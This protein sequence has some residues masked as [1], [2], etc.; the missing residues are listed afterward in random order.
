LNTATLTPHP[1]NISND[2]A[3][4]LI[5]VRSILLLALLVGLF[6]AYR[7]LEAPLAYDVLVMLLAGYSLVTLISAVRLRWARPVS[8]A[9]Y[10][11]QLFID[12]LLLTLLVYFSGGASNPFISLYIVFLT[13]SAA[14]LPRRTTWLLA[15]VTMLA[16]SYLLVYN[17]P[18]EPAGSEAMAHHHHAEPDDSGLFN[19][20]LLGM[21]L[22]FLVSTVLI[23]FFVTR[24]A[25][26]IRIQDA[27]LAEHR[28]RVLQDEQLLAVATQAAG[29]AHEL[30]TPLSTIAVV[31]N[32]LENE[33]ACRDAFGD[34]LALLKGQI[35]L[36]KQALQKLSH[37]AEIGTAGHATSHLQSATVFF[38]GALDRWQLMRPEVHYQ[39]ELAL[40][41]NVSIK[42]GLALQQSVINLLNNAADASPD[43]IEV[44]LRADQAQVVLQIRDYG[45]GFDQAVLEQLGQPFISTKPDG[46]G[47]GL[48][49][50]NATAA[51]YG[52]RIELIN[53][54][55]GGALTE[56]ILPVV[57]GEGDST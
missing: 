14:L 4:R 27:K 57:H 51:R 31:V 45:S 41:E 35:H 30:G 29:T 46:M 22:T 55:G 33:P 25:E 56:L 53:M 34:D 6:Y 47:L 43:R 16:Y 3:W 37:E 5:W 40:P 8:V 20:H 12:V 49:L 17:Q 23:A 32:E 7:Q 44:T 15:T 42:A 9:E 26:A 54:Q 13:I 48:Y 21:W 38:T 19:L 11:C 52:G 10:S 24:M 36:C 2:N 1:I 39:A 28:E 18:L 50:T